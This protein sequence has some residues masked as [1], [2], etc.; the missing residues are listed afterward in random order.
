MVIELCKQATKEL[1]NAIDG[2]KTEAGAD[3]GNKGGSGEGSSG[4]RR[5]TRFA[6]KGG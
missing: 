6:G 4:V 1:R 2:V 3:G 5:S